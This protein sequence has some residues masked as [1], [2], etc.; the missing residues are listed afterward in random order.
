MSNLVES[1]ILDFQLGSMSRSEIYSHLAKEGLVQRER[2]QALRT[3]EDLIRG[4]KM[5]K[6]V[7]SERNGRMSKSIPLDGEWRSVMIVSEK[8]KA[9]W[10]LRTCPEEGTFECGLFKRLGRAFGF[11]GNE[12]YYWLRKLS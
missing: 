7:R 10:Y 1:L 5:L 4:L 3:M 2:K 11:G 9:K 12:F 8:K 6:K